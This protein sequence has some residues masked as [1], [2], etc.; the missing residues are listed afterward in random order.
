MPWADSLLRHKVWRMSRVQGVQ[1]VG[2]KIG[3]VI[4]FSW[5]SLATTDVSAV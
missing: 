1:T 3:L 5:Y 2:F 4:P